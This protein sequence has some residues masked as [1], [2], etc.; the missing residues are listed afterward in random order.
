MPR[1]E[2]LRNIW[3]AFLS[4]WDMLAAEGPHGI[5]WDEETLRDVL[6]IYHRLVRAGVRFGEAFQADMQELSAK[7]WAADCRTF[8]AV[9]SNV[10]ENDPDVTRFECVACE[11]LAYLNSDV[12]GHGWY[13][14][15]ET[16]VGVVVKRAAER[17]NLDPDPIALALV[18]WVSTPIGWS[19]LHNQRDV[20]TLRE[21]KNIISAA[22]VGPQRARHFQQLTTPARSG[23]G[24]R[25]SQA[26][27]LADATSGVSGCSPAPEGV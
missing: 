19:H 21:I 4:L 1:Q 2:E 26:M 12:S 5:D 23:S 9:I 24:R 15:P 16:F 8:P 6:N 18:N 22:C 13:D 7:V 27:P 10:G 14:W 20:E 17:V 11:V 3:R 25:L